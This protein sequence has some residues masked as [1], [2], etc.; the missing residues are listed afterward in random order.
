MKTKKGIW[1]IVLMMLF[2]IIS[3][4][5]VVAFDR[6]T[7]CWTSCELTIDQEEYNNL[8]L[9]NNGMVKIGDEFFPWSVD[10]DGSIKIEDWN[11]D[12]YLYNGDSKSYVK[13]GDF[14]TK[15]TSKK[16]P[17]NQDLFAGISSST[18]QSVNENTFRRGPNAVIKK[19]KTSPDFLNNQPIFK[20]IND[21]IDSGDIVEA[22]RLLEKIGGGNLNNN[23]ITDED[24]RE[25][26]NDKDNPSSVIGR[27]LKELRTNV[28]NAGV[29]SSARRISSDVSSALDNPRT[30]IDFNVLSTNLQ[31]TINSLPGETQ[32]ELIS[33]LRKQKEKVDRWR[34]VRRTVT[35]EDVWGRFIE[36]YN[37][38]GAQD[39]TYYDRVISEM[40]S[41]NNPLFYFNAEIGKLND[42]NSLQ[43]SLMGVVSQSV[44]N[45]IVNKINDPNQRRT[46]L[47]LLDKANKL[48]IDMTNAHDLN[49]I[50][51]ALTQIKRILTSN[52][53]DQE[54]LPNDIKHKISEVLTLD[55]EG[56]RALNGDIKN[57]GDQ[58][59]IF[60]RV[61]RNVEG[62]NWEHFKDLVG[63]PQYEPKLDRLVNEDKIAQL[64]SNI[65]AF[66]TKIDELGVSIDKIHTD[67]LDDLTLAEINQ[68][69]K[70]AEKK[71]LA[72]PGS[73]ITNDQ[74][75]V[76]F[77][78]LRETSPSQTPSTT[79]SSTTNTPERLGGLLEGV[80]DP[81]QISK[82][83]STYNLGTDLGIDLGANE[84]FDSFN[85]RVA[86]KALSQF[87]D[88]L[89][90]I[91]SDG[92]ES[93]SE[94]TF[95]ANP[96]SQNNILRSIQYL[97]SNNPNDQEL[98]HRLI[99]TLIVA[100]KSGLDV[101]EIYGESLD[102][103]IDSTLESEHDKAMYKDYLDNIE[104]QNWLNSLLKSIDQ[105]SA[106]LKEDYEQVKV[107]NKKVGDWFTD[108]AD[109]GADDKQKELNKFGFN[110]VR[111]IE[112]KEGNKIFIFTD[113]QGRTHILNKGA[114]LGALTNEDGLVTPDAIQLNTGFLSKRAGTQDVSGQVY[115]ELAREGLL[116]LSVNDGNLDTKISDQKFIRE[117]TS[118]FSVNDAGKKSGDK[119]A[120]SA[121]VGDKVFVAKSG[122]D[123]QITIDG[124]TNYKT[125]SGRILSEN[126][127]LRD[128]VIVVDSVDD[129]MLYDNLGTLESDTSIYGDQRYGNDPPPGK[130]GMDWNIKTYFKTNYDGSKDYF[131]F[132]IDVDDWRFV[133]E[134]EI[135]GN[136]SRYTLPTKK[137]TAR[138]V[139][140]LDLG[141]PVFEEFD[142][143]NN[144]TGSY[145]NQDGKNINKLL[146]KFSSDANLGVFADPE[147][148]K[149]QI[150]NRQAWQNFLSTVIE[151]PKG[152]IERA[153]VNW[154][155]DKLKSEGLYSPSTLESS[156]WKPQDWEKK[157]C[158]GGA[159]GLLTKHKRP[160]DVKF[161]TDKQGNQIITMS[162]QGS[163]QQ[164][165][166]SIINPNT[167]E[168][169]IGNTNSYEIGWSISPVNEPIEYT[170][171]LGG[172]TDCYL[173]GT[174]NSERQT[175]NP[176]Q[177]SGSY[178]GITSSLDVD[179]VSICYL[180][181]ESTTLQEYKA[182]IVSK[183]YSGF[184]TSSQG[185][186]NVGTSPSSTPSTAQQLPK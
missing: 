183:S 141:F 184:D 116:D 27:Y 148:A 152:P 161:T 89:N 118:I 123:N 23:E 43:N 169:E 60:E 135:T 34:I 77:A 111:E 163:K 49:S 174:K 129:E 30:D 41:Q 107:S 87:S 160:R 131:Y 143:D 126:G 79:T 121:F 166:T 179:V 65:E 130:V 122:E 167:G 12:Y 18:K 186:N 14:R 38:A 155:T 149:K 2:I 42:V 53:L 71:I 144:P 180:E 100:Q 91:Q 170:I 112:D 134:S 124:K 132:D 165:P 157:L 81:D 147:L 22:S 104:N 171:C 105:N 139:Y 5:N 142:E 114:S 117:G 83:R 13:V 45:D 16:V 15:V 90:K 103:I 61:T 68:L 70:N 72:L 48:G 92:S 24:V 59:K 69:V 84:Q 185:P 175:V 10:S 28:N 55:V 37:A 168:G 1:M 67:G 172:C 57:V 21:A 96:D 20:D 46:Q 101:G 177:S 95:G 125:S 58:K 54:D 120:F 93:L 8:Q 181:G 136:P 94:S 82:I 145:V 4:A 88:V 154:V 17:S 182:P 137:V 64:T 26:I 99:S 109:M 176:Q 127:N 156:F 110:D 19:V 108:L 36:N 140:D 78:S 63:T 159:G 151:G 178:A 76:L 150:A 162:L 173:L 138:L 146:N 29:I 6:D 56:M 85:N 75:G 25:A 133:S 44:L 106:N 73:L 3:S 35:D 97:L 66:N 98:R 115:I 51:F 52:R 40:G 158:E 102:R 32:E 33:E 74:V 153:K 50:T 86:T 80:N 113:T 164:I 62:A 39:K 119:I 31:K 47:L 7:W 11:G 9:N 128:D